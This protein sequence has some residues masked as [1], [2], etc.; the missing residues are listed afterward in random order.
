MRAVDAPIAL[1][2]AIAVG[3]SGC[4][5]NPAPKEWRR[6]AETSQNGTLGSWIAIEAKPDRGRLA[7]EFIALD[8]NLLY[9]LTASGL[10]S[11]PRASAPR[12]TVVAYGTPGGSV[13]AWGSPSPPPL[14]SSR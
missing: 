1:T 11:V 10:T 13:A 12:V 4:A 9:V 6:T 14:A 8:D 5:R 3:I 7:G 2:L